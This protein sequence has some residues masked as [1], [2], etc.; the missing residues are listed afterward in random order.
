MAT[1]R[2]IADLIIKLEAQGFQQLEGIR[3]ELNSLASTTRLSNS[4]LASAA[5]EVLQYGKRTSNTTASVKAQITILKSLRDQVG[6]TS[7]AYKGMTGEINKLQQIQKGGF[8]DKQLLAQFPGAK[9][10]TI[11]AQIGAALRKLEESSI[12]DGSYSNALLDA[13]KRQEKFNSQLQE[14]ALITKNLFQMDQSRDLTTTRYELPDPQQGSE[15]I[16]ALAQKNWFERFLHAHISSPLWKKANQMPDPGEVSPYGGYKARRIEEKTDF[17]YGI[18]LQLALP[19]TTNALQF[20]LAKAK[21]EL[22]DLTIGSTQYHRVLGEVAEAQHKYNRAL[23]QTTRDLKNAA[24]MRPVSRDL[25]TARRNLAGSRRVRARAGSGFSE[26]SQDAEFG[27]YSDGR[28]IQKALARRQRDQ[29]K[30]QGF[31]K[32]RNNPMAVSGLY[33][34][35]SNIGMSKVTANIDRMGKSWRTVRKDILAATKAS[36][37]SIS[38]LQAQKS[39]FEQ[40]RVGLDPTSKAFR[41]LTKDISQVDRQLNKLNRASAGK[42]FMGA[43]QGILGASFFGGPAGFLG[44]TA[45]A[46]IQALR[47]QDNLREGAATGGLIA[48]QVLQPIAG[49]GAESANYTAMIEKSKIA[50]EAATKVEGDAIAS[51]EAYAIA[52]GTAASVTERFNV[53]QEL[54]ARGMTRL[55]AAVIGAG[56]NIHNAG[57][58]FENIS[59]AIKATGGSTEDTKA[60][61]TAMVQIFSK[62]R[63]SA[64][65]LSGQLGERFPAAVT[66]FAE[67]NN[68][69]TKELQKGLKDGAIGLDKL[70]NFVLKLGDKYVDVAEGIGA[71]SVEAGVRSQIAWNEVKLAIGSAL[72]P[73]GADLQVIGAEILTGLVPALTKL[74]EVTGSVLKSV[75]GALV[76]ITENLGKVTIVLGTFIT[77]LGIANGQA[78]VAF[79]NALVIVPLT[80]FIKGLALAKV[81]MEAFGA[82][83]AVTTGKMVILNTA[84]QANVFILAA[85]AI[86]GAGVAA[87]HFGRQWQ[88]TVEEIEKGKM[89][90]EEARIKVAELEKELLGESNEKTRQRLQT[91][92]QIYKEAIETRIE[93]VNKAKEAEAKAFE[94]SQPQ[95]MKWDTLKEYVT[96]LQQGGKDLQQVFI[97][98]FKGMEDALT[99]F[100]MTGKLK[101]KEFA[102]SVIADIARMIVK[103]MM[104]NMLS[105]FMNSFNTNSL[106]SATLGANATK[107]TGIP[108]GSDLPY[109]SFGIDQTFGTGIPTRPLAGSFGISTIDRGS[110]ARDFFAPYRDFKDGLRA[111]AL[112]N[113][114]GKNG[115]V[116]FY[117]G[118]VVNR[119]TLFPFANGVGLMSEVGPEAIMPLKR[120]KGGRL[121]VEVAGGGGG[122][123]VN[124]SVDAKGTSVEG[125][126]T[127]AKMLGKML[128]TAVQAEIAKQKRPGGILS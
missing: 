55:S 16:K 1:G 45:G 34:Q 27:I 23:S 33:D 93:L 60:A 11:K 24:N 61:V 95:T 26:F 30:I 66:L 80:S 88:R 8:S 29:A 47:G 99:N 89:P 58:A 121:G 56:G 35:I 84:M 123:V 50:L 54:A 10:R 5:K 111:N 108:S 70:W 52:L 36:N 124:I 71:A 87:W 7:R 57:V 69:T 109:G 126:D 114:Y 117:K 94:S 75:S 43:A 62:G 51:K 82:A 122:T 44:A 72:Q 41:Q 48:S 83:A 86:A 92:I 67:A 18:P 59:A 9:P 53:P 15:G 103:Q 38:S 128:S 105:G 116:P 63:V 118:G 97:N 37:G 49:F 14:Q 110:P 91:Q 112:G 120:G 102:R 6:L 115:I 17:K 76:V 4:A 12:T 119:P 21:E 125:Q 2:S 28:A 79:A 107:M 64:E 101:F 78:L 98:A 68:M 31:T 74:A 22:G 106:N 3:K 13:T 42:R 20:G 113:V 90:L 77:A 40:L 73:I 127:Q 46:G 81:T 19:Q 39:A 65:E 96:D 32:A 104:F 100:V 25:L 85:T